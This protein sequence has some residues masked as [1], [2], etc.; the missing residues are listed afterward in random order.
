MAD[1]LTPEEL[2]QAITDTLYPIKAYELAATCERLGLAPEDPEGLHP[3]SSKTMY[4]RER[5]LA[6]DMSALVVLARKVVEEFGD[7]VW[8][9]RSAAWVRGH[10]TAR[11]RT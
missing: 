4:I 11:S 10:R 2:R 9:T 8:R 7:N 3:F 1:R 6:L 5:L